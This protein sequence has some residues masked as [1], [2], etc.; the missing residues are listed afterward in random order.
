MRILF[1]SAFYPPPVVG[2]WEQL[3]EEINQHL[4]A[5]GHTTHVLTSTHGSNTISE[6]ETGVD[7]LLILESDLAHY[8]PVQSFLGRKQRLR[9]NLHH[10]REAIVRFNPDIVFVHVMWNLSSGIPWLAEQLCPGRVVYYV[11]NDWPYAADTH[12]DYWRQ[13]ARRLTHRLPKRLLAAVAL[14]TIAREARDFPLQFQRV[15]CVSQAVR[16]DLLRNTKIAPEAMHVV[17]NG[18]DLDAFAPKRPL[19]DQGARSGRLALVYAGSLVPH[20]G[21]RTAIEAMGHLHHTVGP[22]DVHLTVVGSGHPDYEANLRD[23]VR[24]EE[25]G[26]CVQFRGRVP[27]EE[28]PDLLRQ[29]EALIF[30]STWQEPLA[31]M[32]QEAM[33]AGLVVIGTTTGGTSEILF[34]GET[35]LTFEPED[36]RQLARQIERLRHDPS[37]RLRLSQNAQDRVRRDFDICRTVNQIEQHL[38]WAARSKSV[39]VTQ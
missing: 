21:V 27:R 19:G 9:I 35:G 17:Y 8:N 26:A 20:K 5:R 33:A 37:L 7:R 24:R 25:L 12:T 2:G 4:T 39:V 36:A 10:T 29:F 31:R 3:V 28:M 23:M 6:L 14:K 38:V 16:N 30:P 11:A 18:I 34:E 32:V 1:I 22:D 15:L 13:A